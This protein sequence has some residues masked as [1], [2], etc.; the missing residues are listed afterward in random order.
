MPAGVDQD[1]T[2]MNN[3]HFTGAIDTLHLVPDASILACPDNRTL[4]VQRALIDQCE[5]LAD[6]F[7]VLDCPQ[8]NAY[9][10]PGG[11][12]FVTRGLLKALRGEAELAGILSHE[13]AH[14]NERHMYRELRP[15][16]EVSAGESIVRML[17][18]GGST[19]GGDIPKTPQTGAKSARLV[20]R[21]V[22]GWRLAGWRPAALNGAFRSRNM[23]TRGAHRG[24]TTRRNPAPTKR[25]SPFSKNR[26]AVCRSAWISRCARAR[27]RLRCAP[28]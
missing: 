17:S 5:L 13:V 11:Y 4:T 28:G 14:I 21:G 3:A 19:P 1:V 9:A 20:R 18:R 22:M 6:R 27:P 24:A 8:V 15:Q 23:A 2:L 26:R 16:K 12:V 10:T 7:A 25:R